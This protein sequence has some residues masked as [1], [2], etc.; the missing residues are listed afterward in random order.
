MPN[1]DWRIKK[2]ERKDGTS[3]SYFRSSWEE[4]A[5]EGVRRDRKS[6]QKTKKPLISQGLKGG[7]GDRGRTDDLMLGKHTL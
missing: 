3:F 4:R 5:R 6:E 7:A 1:G 2:G